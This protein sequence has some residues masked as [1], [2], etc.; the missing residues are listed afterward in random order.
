MNSLYIYLKKSDNFWF[1]LNRPKKTFVIIKIYHVG[2]FISLILLFILIF[3]SL[4]IYL[5]HCS[6]VELFN[7]VN[8]NSTPISIG[9]L[10]APTMLKCNTPAWTIPL[11]TTV[12]P[13]TRFLTKSVKY[14]I[15]WASISRSS[16][17]F[18]AQSELN[19]LQDSMNHHFNNVSSQYGFEKNVK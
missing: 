1:V 14:N 4:F 13:Y 5:F 18:V 16:L 19:K 2:L 3:I 9:L 10:I 15:I 8:I 7:Y 17:Y 11:L 12:F 6:N